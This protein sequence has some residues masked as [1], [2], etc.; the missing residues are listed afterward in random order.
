M[1][2]HDLIEKLRAFPQDAKVIV[3]GYESDMTE[4]AAATPTK[5]TVH[6]NE[7]EEGGVCG[8]FEECTGRPEVAE[9]WCYHCEQ[10]RPKIVAVVIER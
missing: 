1:T 8:E 10:G 2:V 4:P 3:D 7:K 5:R 6:R 9:S